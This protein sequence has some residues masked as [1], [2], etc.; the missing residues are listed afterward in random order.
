[1]AH[2]W[3]GGGALSA[4]LYSIISPAVEIDF[5]IPGHKLMPDIFCYS[6]SFYQLLSINITNNQI[7]VDG[8]IFPKKQPSPVGR[9]RSRAATASGNSAFKEAHIWNS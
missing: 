3:F 1:M 7:N 8:G 2:A 6:F 9:P 4:L 5:P